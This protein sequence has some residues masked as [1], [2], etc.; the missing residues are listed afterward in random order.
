[1]ISSQIDASVLS[2]NPQP[3][4]YSTLHVNKPSFTDPDISSR[5][6]EIAEVNEM[7]IDVFKENQFENFFDDYDY[8]DKNI[9][10]KIFDANKVL[11]DMVERDILDADWGRL[12]EEVIKFI[13]RSTYKKT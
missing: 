10:E 6:R 9:L 7:D 13:E 1:M 4:D 8:F 3:N 12:S 2:P 11:R 5:D